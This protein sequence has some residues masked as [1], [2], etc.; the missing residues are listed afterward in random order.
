MRAG[1]SKVLVLTLVLYGLLFGRLVAFLQF[2]RVDLDPSPF[3]GRRVVQGHM[4][5]LVAWWKLVVI[6]ILLAVYAI[7]VAF[8]ARQRNRVLPLGQAAVFVFGV[9]ALLVFATGW[10]YVGVALHPIRDVA[11]WW[12]GVLNGIPG[13]LVLQL[14]LTAIV[15]SLAVVGVLELAVKRRRKE[16]AA[17]KGEAA[18]PRGSTD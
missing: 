9:A 1:L 8:A 10:P 15:Q 18:R 6:G 12:I 13:G 5:H 14:L 4:V 11:Q 3:L 16:D 17:T 7:L 2:G